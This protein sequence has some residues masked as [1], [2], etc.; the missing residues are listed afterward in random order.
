[1]AILGKHRIGLLRADSGFFDGD[2]LND[3]EIKWLEYM[4]AVRMNP[5]IKMKI[6]A[7]RTWTKVDGGI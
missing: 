2:F 3:L 1:M 5:V 6:Q 7:I 4:I